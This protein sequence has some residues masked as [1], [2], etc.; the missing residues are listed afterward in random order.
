ML[1]VIGPA[2][3]AIA[4]GGCQ[5]G[6]HLTIQYVL[7]PTTALQPGTTVYVM[8]AQVN[9]AT[10]RKWSEM[11]ANRIEELLREAGHRYHADIRIA[12]RKHLA[13]LMQEQDLAAAGVINPAEAAR[14]GMVAGADAVVMSEIN[15]RIEGHRT[16]RP[17]VTGIDFHRYPHGGGGGIQVGEVE[18]VARN[19]IVQT[20][21]KL[22]DTTTSRVWVSYSPAPVSRF[23]ETQTSPIFGS[24]R[25]EGDLIAR[26][27]VIRQA[28]EEGVAGFV[29]RVVPLRVEYPILVTSSGRQPCIDGVKSLR[30]DN[31]ESALAYFRQ[32]LQE[33]ADHQAAYGAGVASEKLGRFHDAIDYY[34][35]AYQMSPRSEY[36]EAKERLSAHLGRIRSGSSGGTSATSMSYTNST[37]GI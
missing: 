6:A 16:V 36:L 4:A 15:V 2:L 31:Y 24:S 3:L 35:K 33:A 25:G 13:Q 20:D 26:D 5:Q 37:A 10:D 23:D 28:V 11:A 7:E 18:G 29:S 32:S 19:I 22:I 14:S 27:E 34:R 8:D 12:S 9:E 17:T 30:A 1:Q 21:F